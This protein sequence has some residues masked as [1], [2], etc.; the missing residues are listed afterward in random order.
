MKSVVQISDLPDVISVD[1]L[2]DVKGGIADTNF[3]CS[4][5]M[6]AVTCNVAGSGMCTAVGSGICTV[7]DSG[8][9]K[10]PEPVDPNPGPTPADPEPTPGT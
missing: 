6:N 3:F 4:S 1:E 9:I 8:F 2:M 7:K 5:F 10:D